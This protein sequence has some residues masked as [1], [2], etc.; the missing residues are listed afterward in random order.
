MKFKTNIK[1]SACVATV[2]P[3]LDAA[4]G[5]GNWQV[6]LTDPL[7]VLTLSQGKLDVD[8][9]KLELEGVGYQVEQISVA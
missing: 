7:R 5:A 8:S 1:C 2:T 4:V 6:D 9:L 3:I